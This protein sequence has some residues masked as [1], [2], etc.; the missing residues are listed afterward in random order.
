MEA[1]KSIIS[2]AIKYGGDYNKILKAIKEKE[3]VELS[4]YQNCFTIFDDIYPKAFLELKYPPFVLFYKGNLD[5]LKK[6]KIAIVGSRIPSDYAIQATKQLS[7]NKS[8][9][10][11]VSGLAKGIDGIAHKYANKSIGILG[12][13]IDYIY[14]KENI[15]LYKKLEKEGL[16]ISEYPSYTKPYGFHFPFRNRL[17][18]ALSKEVYIMEAHEKSG[19]VTTINEALELG[20][21]IKVLPFNVFDSNGIYNN[22]LIQEGALIITNNDVRQ[23]T[24]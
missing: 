7:L 24:N 8:D 22:Y 21:D 13:G 20:R 14:P 10:V 12:S 18:A 1:R 16:I 19:T 4:D 3:E 5:L 17:I 2:L 15:M 23:L 11:I 9:K 6:D